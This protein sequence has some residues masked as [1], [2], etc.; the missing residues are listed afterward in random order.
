MLKYIC[1]A[2]PLISVLALT[3]LVFSMGL[4]F[5]RV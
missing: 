4:G 1:K 3:V 5:D 2:R